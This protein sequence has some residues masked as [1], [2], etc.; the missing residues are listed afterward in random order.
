MIWRSGGWRAFFETGDVEQL[1]AEVVV[2]RGT[3]ER[4]RAGELDQMRMFEVRDPMGTRCGS[5]G[6][7]GRAIR[8]GWR[9][10]TWKAL[11]ESPGDNVGAAVKY[12]CEAL[13]FRINYQ[14]C[15]LGVMDREIYVDRCGRAACGAVEKGLERAGAGEPS[16]GPRDF[17]VPDL[18]ESRITF[19]QTFE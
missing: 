8:R 6:R 12:H 17:R 11:S 7:G 18:N 15:D 5:R 13:G 14:Q 4:D 3:G 1:R 9:P 16:V 2:A 19:A 10:G